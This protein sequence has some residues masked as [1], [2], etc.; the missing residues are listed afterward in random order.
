MYVRC[1][2]DE[3]FYCITFSARE[4]NVPK[5]ET[6]EDRCI[7]ILHDDISDSHSFHVR[8]KEGFST[9]T[10]HSF[11]LWFGCNKNFL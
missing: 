2:A 8:K 3:K 1:I 10:T 4:K 11:M 9:L 7:I 6:H 5:K